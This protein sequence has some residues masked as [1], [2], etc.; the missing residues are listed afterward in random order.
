LLDGILVYQYSIEAHPYAQNFTIRDFLSNIFMLQNAPSMHGWF[1]KL[2]FGA[3]QF[4]TGRPLWTLGLEW[5]LYISF[6]MWFFFRSAIFKRRYLPFFLAAAYVPFVNTMS[7]YADG[8]AWIWIMGAALYFVHKKID[9]RKIPLNRY[10]IVSAIFAI[11]SAFTLYTTRRLYGQITVY[12]MR[13]MVYSTISL[14]AIILAAQY[15]P[16]RFSK[17]K[18]A[19]KA[20]TFMSD[21]SYTLYLIHYSVLVLM[22]KALAE[23]NAWLTFFL[24]ILASNVLALMIA[25]FTEFRHKK[26]AEWLTKKFQGYRKRKSQAY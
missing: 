19:P 11:M 8:L 3:Q 12:D 25:Y 21:Y 9:F 5:W 22:Q 26:L 6:G 7:A 17:Y 23:T 16:K 4:G 1:S 20:L 13:F 15:Y 24:C 10:I 2:F 14:A 18:I